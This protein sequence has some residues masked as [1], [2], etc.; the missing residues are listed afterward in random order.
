MSMAET[1][2]GA[3]G[4]IPGSTARL[5]AFVTLAVRWVQGWI[6]WGGGSRRFIYAPSKLD[7]TA[8]HWMANKFQSALP[9]ALFGLRPIGEWFLHHGSFLLALLVVISLLELISGL[10]L[11]IG[12]F[13]RLSALLTIGISAGLMLLFGWQGATCID[14]WTMSVSNFAMGAVVLVAGGGAWSLDSWWQRKRPALATAGWFRWL[15]SG[16]LSMP[17][18]ETGGK[19][20]AV[21]S[22]VFTVGFYNYYRGSVLTPYHKG[23]VSPSK[24]QAKLESATL[25]PSGALQV[26]TYISGGTEA[27]PAFIVHIALRDSQDKIVEQWGGQMLSALPKSAIQNEFPY[28][29]IQSG[30]YGLK[31]E[32]GAR[33][34]LRLPPTSPALRLAPGTY[35]VIFQS[36]EGPRFFTSAQVLG[37]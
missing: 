18:L 15:G 36:I 27:V 16:P 6:Y 25:T 32:V 4:T 30:I 7:P 19:W 34:W 21:I 10:G 9:G 17:Q 26:K 37:G 1:L 35:T 24:H 33:A 2:R 12:F 31:G 28:N 5:L 29:R 13:T 3:S 14:E 8:H 20:L 11:L 23:P 22:I